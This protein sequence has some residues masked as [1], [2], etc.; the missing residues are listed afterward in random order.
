MPNVESPTDAARSFFEGLWQQGDYWELEKSPFEQ[1]KYARQMEL[2]SG[3]RYHRV[4]E[5]GCGAGWFTRSLATISDRVVAIDVA[6]AAIERAIAGGTAGGT[7]DFRVGDIMSG[8][9]G[10][11]G[12]FDL[13]VLAET[14]YY[15]GWLYSFF[16][17]GWLAAQLFDATADNGIFVMTNTHVGLS[18]YL[19]RPWLIQTYRDLFRNVGYHL[20][21]ANSFAAEKDGVP[22]E[23]AIDLYRKP[24]GATRIAE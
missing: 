4:L 17:I 11:E 2:I 23:A 1:A 12:P 16:K 7:I 6:P 22:L 21:L 5:I 14:I 13:I 20:D 8:D 19:H 24:V 18:S 3:R 9:P 10:A 15:L